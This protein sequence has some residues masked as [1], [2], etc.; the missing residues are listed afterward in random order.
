MTAAFN[1]KGL[2]VS[3]H[4]REDWVD[5]KGVQ[6]IYLHAREDWSVQKV[7]EQAYEGSLLIGDGYPFGTLALNLHGAKMGNL[8]YES[9]E[10]LI[11]SANLKEVANHDF[12]L[13]A[14]SRKT[15]ER[16][17]QSTQAESLAGKVLA[18]Y[19]INFLKFTQWPDDALNDEVLRFAIV[20]D[21]ITY[22]QILQ[23]LSENPNERNI[24]GRTLEVSFLDAAEGIGAYDAVYMDYASGYT[25]SELLGMIEDRPILLMTYGYGYNETMLNI[26][27]EGNTVQFQLNDEQATAHRLS[28][29]DALYT[30]ASEVSEDDWK[31]LVSSY[32]KDLQQEKAKNRA[33][34]EEVDALTAEVNKLGKEINVRSKQ[35]KVI[36][37]RIERQLR[38]LQSMEQEVALKAAE[39]G[40][41]QAE[42]RAMEDEVAKKE[43]AIDAA[44][45][46]L[47][48][49]REELT[50]LVDNY[51]EVEAQM[52]D[53]LKLLNNQRIVIYGMV[54]IA[55]IFLL[56]SGVAYYNFRKQRQHAKVIAAQKKQVETQRD[57]I[58]EK[59]IQLEEKNREITDSI[60]YAKR[61]QDAILPPSSMVDEYLNENFIL[62][63]PKDI[64]AGDFYWLEPINNQVYFAA[65][66]CT[67]HGVPG[68]MVSVLCNNGLNRSV[69]EFGLR[70]PGE[71][72]S[73]TRELVIAE[74]EKSEEEVKD[75][76]D[77]A[78]CAF[79]RE[80][81]TLEFAGAQN[82]L[83][84]ISKR[85]S[86]G[87]GVEQRSAY[88]IESVPDVYLHEIKAD[89]EPIGKYAS[90]TP[91]SN[92]KVQLEKG[93]VIY[94][95]SDGYADQFGGDKGKKFKYRAFKDLLLTLHKL[96]MEEQHQ[97]IEERFET[98]RGD[99]EQIDD[100]CVMGVRV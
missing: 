43:A 7:S 13:E 22:D 15:L 86:L 51:H 52:S 75:G 77:I 99:L 71:I 34:T 50:A 53:A 48:E 69:R 57:E 28:F 5:W 64:V 59:S 16:Q 6:I 97:H 37:M 49:Q 42:V 65:A 81:Y 74:F 94:L 68:A 2:P 10:R 80:K 67:G 63:K 58:T 9:N 98:W 93:D 40:S 100:V 60:T 41:A 24:N 91:F 85:P 26:F 90:S 88:S 32:H 83:W 84:V 19:T 35:L 47:N 20:Q 92:H 1:L 39:L 46:Q 29:A 44:E 25:A 45:L 70:R 55:F 62:Y 76:M 21:S 11:K 66:D 8:V 31:E 12:T 36:Q 61:I 54:V 89:K 96:P 4:H 18:L 14:A 73:K 27:K 87:E 17:D 38:E 56:L 30:L 33:L 79:D 23:V 3:V 82:P 72:L 95:F 78:F